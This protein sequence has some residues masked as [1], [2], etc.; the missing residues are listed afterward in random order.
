MGVK[1][2]DYTISD[3]EFDQLHKM[4]RGIASKF[5]GW[6]GMHVDDI[7]I[8]LWIKTTQIV[9]GW[10]GEVVPNFI[11]RCC[12]NEAKSLYRKELKHKDVHP[13]DKGLLEIMLEKN[14]SRDTEDDLSQVH[15]EEIIGLFEEGTKDKEYVQMLN[16][17]LQGDDDE[18]YDFESRV[19]NQEIALK[20]GYA[21]ST[22]NGYRRLK[23]R[24][25]EVIKE[26]YLNS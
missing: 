12:Y 5:H 11:A 26:Y 1:V 23:Y 21:N 7:E 2:G 19:M 4:V 13:Y 22:S 8:D 25:G 20:L 10:N 14:D 16:T 15:I 3:E 17:Y 24:V 6:A 18:K 9:N